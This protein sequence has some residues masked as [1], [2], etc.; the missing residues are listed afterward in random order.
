MYAHPLRAVHVRLQM[1]H[2]AVWCSPFYP[3]AAFHA[4]G[5]LQG[6]IEDACQIGVRDTPKIDV[7]WHVRSGVPM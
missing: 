2:A 6:A 5:G 7:L 3:D 1:E 4:R